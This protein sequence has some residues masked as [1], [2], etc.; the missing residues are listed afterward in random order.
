MTRAD[1]K[2]AHDLPRMRS[3]GAGEIPDATALREGACRLHRAHA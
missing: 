2:T 1:R 3:A